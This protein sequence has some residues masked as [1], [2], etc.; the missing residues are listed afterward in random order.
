MR[1]LCCLLLC[2]LLLS[3]TLGLARPGVPSE[4][5]WLYDVT[6]FRFGNTLYFQIQRCQVATCA[7]TCTPVDIPGATAAVGDCW[8]VPVA[9]GTFASDMTEKTV[10]IPTTPARFIRFVATSEIDGGPWTSMAALTAYDQGTLVPQS[11]TVTVMADSQEFIGE[12]GEVQRIRDDDTSTY[13]HTEWF[14][15]SPPQPHQ[16]ILDLGAVHN[17]NQIKYLPRQDGSRR[18]TVIG[19]TIYLAVSLSASYLDTDVEAG[20]SWIYTTT[21]VGILFGEPSISR[22]SNA[23]CHYVKARRRGRP[24]ILPK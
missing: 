23:V 9:S 1:R 2:L 3:P 21:A 7:Q 18:G 22:P 19:Y 17:V 8:G 16:V 10:T 11:Q 14:A 24:D 20:E 4:L 12:A 6:Q 5:A 13:W 15:A